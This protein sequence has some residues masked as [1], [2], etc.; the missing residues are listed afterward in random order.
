MKIG[1]YGGSFNPPHIGHKRLVSNILNEKLVDK[2]IILP[3]NNRYNKDDLANLR[4]RVNMLKE[5]FDDVD[6]VEIESED[7]I[8]S[9][10]Y[11]YMALKYYSEEYSD[12]DIFFIMGS[13]NLREFSTWKFWQLIVSQYNLIVVIRNEDKVFEL[14]NIIPNARIEFVEAVGDLSSTKIRKSIK[15]GK[16]FMWFLDEGV[17]KYIKENNLYK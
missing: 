15:D 1:I 12:A 16:S 14:E 7:I 8:K 17:E 6:N 3:T 5:C 4:H 2:I 11:T 9:L 13:D 10:D